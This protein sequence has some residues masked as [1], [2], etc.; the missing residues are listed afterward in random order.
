[1]PIVQP[2]QAANPSGTG[3]ATSAGAA[4]FVAPWEVATMMRR[5]GFPNTELAQGV[6]IVGAESGFRIAADNGSHV[7]LFQIGD[8]KGY[9]RNLLKTDPQYNVNA[10]YAV[11]K[12]Q[13][14]A[15]G[16]LNYEK[17][18]ST[19]FTTVAASAVATSQKNVPNS[20]LASWTVH[21]DDI[22]AL[23]EASGAVPGGSA[24]YTA[25]QS[26]GSGVGSIVSALGQLDTWERA[27][28]VIGGGVM[29]VLGAVLLARIST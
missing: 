9:D 12:S 5:A 16:W 21:T 19:K 3:P 23:H 25:V 17:G 6:A 2:G 29:F 18:S 11:W 26:A 22:S 10:A 13:G 27:G 1:M 15:R 24:A 28:E 4:L 14:W 20:K 8:D 7:G